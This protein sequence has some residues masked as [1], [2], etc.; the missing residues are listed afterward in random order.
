MALQCDA[1]IIDAELIEVN[2]D[3]DQSTVFVRFGDITRAV[4]SG[5]YSR[6]REVNKNSLF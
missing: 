2:D 4:F 3:L 6:P 5:R 1:I